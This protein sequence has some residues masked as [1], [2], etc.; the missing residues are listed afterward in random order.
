MVFWLIKN[1]FKLNEFMDIKFHP[2]GF[3]FSD[4][5]AWE[6]GYKISHDRLNN[7][8]KKLSNEFTNKLRNCVL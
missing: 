6:V 7:E 8:Q 4:M 5:L 2:L 1:Y 3:I